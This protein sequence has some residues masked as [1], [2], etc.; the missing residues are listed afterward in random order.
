M[1][2]W[3]NNFSAVANR[4]EAA[5]PELYASER[6]D[7]DCKGAEIAFIGTVPPEAEILAKTISVPVRL[8]LSNGTVPRAQ[9]ERE[10]RS[11]YLKIHQDEEVQNANGSLDTETTSIQFEIQPKKNLED[12]SLLDQRDLLSRL[13]R[14]TPSNPKISTS[15]SLVDSV[16]EIQAGPDSP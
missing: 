1:F 12:L 16:G 10:M 2:D 7:A 8:R 4:L 9:L 15:F 3:Q 14:V 6:V 13:S 11:A 5:Y